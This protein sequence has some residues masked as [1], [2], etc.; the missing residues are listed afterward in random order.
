[1]SE[2]LLARLLNVSRLDARTNPETN[3]PP[4]E[5]T[6]YF[7]DPVRFM[8]ILTPPGQDVDPIEVGMAVMEGG[9]KVKERQTKGKLT[10]E[11]RI[12]ARQAWTRAVGGNYTK[13]VTDKGFEVA[14]NLDNATIVMILHQISV[15]CAHLLNMGAGDIKDIALQAGF[16][17]MVALSDTLFQG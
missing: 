1:M 5:V 9:R 4:S 6:Q 16:L 7:R 14:V 11:D 13:D 8:G 10:I 12:K 15:G 2:S 17:R 3:L